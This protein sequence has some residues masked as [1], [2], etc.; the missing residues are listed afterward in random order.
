MPGRT[1]AGKRYAEAVA[2]IARQD[3]S[4]E[5]WRRDLDALGQ[6]LAD[7]QLRLTLE[8][9]RILPERKQRMLNE[10]F[11]GRLAPATLNLL[12]VMAQRGRLGLLPDVITWFDEIADRA[13]GVRRYTVTT[14]VPLSDDQRAQ[15]RQRLGGTRGGQVVLTERVDSSI[16]GGMV[17]RHEDVITDYS[18][19]TRLETLRDRLN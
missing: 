6:A 11:G 9:P 5:Q 7:Q 16:M 2:G 19:K 1:S 17:L 4:W 3:G 15:L 18:V 13:L 10:A 8:S 14:A 12:N